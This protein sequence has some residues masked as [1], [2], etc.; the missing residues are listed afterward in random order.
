[1]AAAVAKTIAQDVAPIDDMKTEKKQA[2]KDLQKTRL[3]V[4]FIEGKCGYGSSCTFAH[5]ADE[6]RG[7]PDLR[8]TQL[9]TKFME[10]NCSDE[11]CTYAHGLEELRDSPNFKKKMCKW[12]SKGQCRNGKKCGFAH[13]VTELRGMEPPPPPPGFKP[14]SDSSFAPPPGLEMIKPE[15]DPGDLSTEAPS[16]QAGNA[17]KAA[18]AD[19]QLFHLQAARGAA[20]LKQ[21]VALMSSAVVALQTKLAALEGMVVQTQVGQMQQQIQQLS[22]QCWALENGLGTA[23]PQQQPTKSRLSAKASPF[24]PIL[25]GDCQWAGSEDST[26]VGSD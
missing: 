22:E 26:S 13:S 11:N 2:N 21:Q 3:C 6:I 10:G 12:N 15:V 5:D 17:D 1:M 20:P 8:K 9:C 24:V 23:E 14:S 16:S 4:Y 19:M 18:V 7:V 25:N